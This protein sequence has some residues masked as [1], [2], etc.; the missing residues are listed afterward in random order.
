MPSTGSVTSGGGLTS[1]P[2]LVEEYNRLSTYEICH[3]GEEI[4][5]ELVHKCAEFSFS[6]R[7]IANYLLISD[8]HQFVVRK[9]KLDETLK[10]FESILMRLRIAGAIIN[11][12]K[13]AIQS[14]KTSKLD[15]DQLERLKKE[16]LRFF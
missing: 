1:D 10:S 13:L 6:L 12:R 5:Q 4:V 7:Q 8:Q 14:Q 2:Q 9:N 11:E 3:H 16:V 15:D